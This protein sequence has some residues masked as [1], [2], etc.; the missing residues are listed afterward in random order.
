MAKTVFI[1]SMVLLSL[2]SVAGCT[3]MQFKDLF[4][5][6]AQQM[7]KVRSAQLVGDFKQAETLVDNLSPTQNNYALSLLEKGRLHFLANDWAASRKQF[8]LAAVKIEEE[9]AKAKIRLS[10]GLA[11]AGAML[12]N[13]NVIDY[14]VPPYEQSML[15]TYQALNYLY[16]GNLEGAIVEIKRA[17]LVQENALLQNEAELQDAE[18]KFNQNALKQAYP[19][20]EA[21]IGK[22]KNS[23]QNA[24][25]FYLSGV[26]YEAANQPNDAYIDYKRALEIYPENPYIQQDV[27]RLASSLAMT[28]DLERFSQKYGSYKAVDNANNNGIVVLIVEQGVINHKDELTV[29]LPIFTRRSDMRFF[30]FSLPVYQGGINHYKSLSTTFD[31]V[32]Y[33]SQQVLRLQALASK[34]LQEQLPELVT[35]Q[36]LRIVAKEQLRSSMSKE[37][38]DLGNILAGLY[39]LAS[40]HADTRSWITLPD[41]VQIMRLTL[42]QGAH[43]LNLKLANQAK[44]VEL[45]VK[46]NRIT[47][48]TLSSIGNYLGHKVTNL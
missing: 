15:H 28:D 26:L 40:E 1:R 12:S 14:Q 48:V 31:D 35:R 7:N 46:K 17:N 47:L 6:Y 34:Q 19:S 38:G 8:A 45:E 29:N 5:G 2:L 44:E 10:R 37:G 23:F 11:N 18:A 20:M 25:T 32:N 24:Y 21:M 33:N 30:S 13:D 42:P 22:L 27:L 41:E 39:N 3:S 9:Q 36:A 43:K 4:S 16:L